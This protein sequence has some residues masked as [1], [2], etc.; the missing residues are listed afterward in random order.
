MSYEHIKEIMMK[1]CPHIW[2]WWNEEIKTMLSGEQLVTR[3][4]K[5]RLELKGELESKILT[6][7]KYF[8]EYELLCLLAGVKEPLDFSNAK[9]YDNPQGKKFKLHKGWKVYYV[10]TNLYELEKKA[11]ERDLELSEMDETNYLI[12]AMNLRPEQILV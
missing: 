3:Y 6:E 4:K 2:K 8:A 1:E 10:G 7:Q 5:A 12:A 9:K 11:K